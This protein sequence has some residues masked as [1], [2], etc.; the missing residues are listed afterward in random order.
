MKYS[1]EIYAKA[2]IEVFEKIPSNEKDSAIKRFLEIINSNGD[3]KRIDKIV[4]LVS[5]Y[6]TLKAGGHHVVI[7]VARELPEKTTKEIV[8]KFQ[9]HDQIEISINP[10]LIAGTRITINGESELDNSLTRK[11][12]KIFN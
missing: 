5:K 12:K 6:L 11:L 9:D 8:K 7:E 1:P 10:Y 2:L 3:M 4:N